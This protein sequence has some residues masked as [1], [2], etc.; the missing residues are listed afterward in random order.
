M[1]NKNYMPQESG[2]YPRQ[3]GWFNIQKNQLI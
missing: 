2:I 3:L 1:Y